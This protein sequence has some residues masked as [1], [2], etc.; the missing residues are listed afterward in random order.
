MSAFLP[1]SLSQKGRATNPS[2]KTSFVGNAVTQGLEAVH[3]PMRRLKPLSYGRCFCHGRPMDVTV[4]IN[5]EACGSA[6]YSLGFGGGDEAAIR[7]NDCGA[8]QGS[9]GELKAV[10]AARVLDQSAEA[11]LSKLETLRGAAPSS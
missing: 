5:C 1:N 6:N 7:C 8:D 2:P 3:T 9:L 11:R 4:E 10:M